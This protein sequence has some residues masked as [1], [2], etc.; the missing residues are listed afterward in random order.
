MQDILKDLPD[1]G[2]VKVRVFIEDEEV[3][4]SFVPIDELRK[5]LFSLK[6]YLVKD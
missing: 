3:L 1:R 2:N 5:L 6:E 4:D